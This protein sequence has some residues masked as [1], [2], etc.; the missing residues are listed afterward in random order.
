[1]FKILKATQCEG[2]FDG[3]EIGLETVVFTQ[4]ELISLN[5]TKN[6]SNV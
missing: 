3:E 5:V 1:M 4:V 2:K 6:Y